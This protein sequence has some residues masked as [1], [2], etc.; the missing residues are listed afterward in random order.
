[1][2]AGAVPQQ[3]PG[4]PMPP[5]QV[6]PANMT[7]SQ[8]Y[9]LAANKFINAIDERNPMMKEPVG[10]TIYEYI[11][12]I[13][14]QQKAPK[15]TGMLINLPLEQIRQLMRSYDVLVLKVQEANH[16]LEQQQQ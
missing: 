8:K 1:M 2:G 13:V 15:I 3:M 6:N 16:L 5:Q 4:M 14:G 12:E 11:T 9:Q 10:N 7:V